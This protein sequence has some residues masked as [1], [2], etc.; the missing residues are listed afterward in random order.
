MSYFLGANDKLPIHPKNFNASAG[1]GGPGPHGPMAPPVGPQPVNASAA[2]TITIHSYDLRDL[3]VV[4]SVKNQ[5]KCGSCVHF[6]HCGLME[7][8]Y[9]L[10]YNG[11]H[12]NLAEQMMLDCAVPEHGYVNNAGCNGNIMEDSGQFLIDHGVTHEHHYKYKAKQD[13]CEK[14]G[15]EVVAQLKDYWKVDTSVDEWKNVLYTLRQP[16]AAAF[17]VHPTFMHY[18]TGVFDGCAPPHGYI[19]GH[20][21]LVTGFGN[22]MGTEYWIVKN[23]WGSSWGEKGFFKYISGSSFCKFE[24]WG[25]TG[26]L[27]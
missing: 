23:S 13:V 15:K 24:R 8:L 10:K 12:V 20:A 21:V 17:L 9:A 18:R 26:V 16:I 22:F 19:G 4:T 14:E 27:V 6:A 3:G 25:F 1:P 11:L 5:K 2:S 7:A